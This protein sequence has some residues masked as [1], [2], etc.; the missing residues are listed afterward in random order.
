VEVLLDERPE[1]VLLLAWNFSSEIVQQQ[2]DYVAAGGRFY[3]PV[4]VPHRIA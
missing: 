1:D 3:V 4:P 2:R